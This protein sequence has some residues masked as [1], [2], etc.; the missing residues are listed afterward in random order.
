[1][2]CI[3]VVNTFNKNAQS[4]VRDIEE[5][6]DSKGHK[7]I[8]VPFSGKNE[9]FSS[10]DYDCA[11]TLG[12]DGTVLY[13]ARQ[14][15]LSG[16]PVFPVNFG[17]FGFIAGTKPENWQSSLNDFFAGTSTL[18]KRSLMYAEVLRGGNS[19][20]SGNALNDV[21][22]SSKNAAQTISLDIEADGIPFGKFKAD[23]IIVATSTGSTAYSAAAGGPIVDPALDAIIFNPVSAFS[24]S[25]RPLVLPS[26]TVL[27]ITVLSSRNSDFVLSYDGQVHTD[28]KEGDCVVVKQSPHKVLLVGC[29][30]AV[31]YEALR[32]KLHWSGG[33]LA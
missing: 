14:C 7:C 22:I 13:A 18:S 1:M 26:E 17:E 33:P 21:L 31:F 30:S 6:L 4:I 5:F 19:V 24:L 12:G 8:I 20:Y 9:D 15:A 23:G 29:S 10:I 32:S 27:Q 28:I 11:I 16:K 25:N 3:V 2:T